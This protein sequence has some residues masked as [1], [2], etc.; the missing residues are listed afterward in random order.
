MIDSGAGASSALVYWLANPILNPAVLVFIGF[1]LGWQ[2]AALRLFVGVVLVFVLANLAARVLFLLTGIHP[3]LQSDL[4]TPTDRSFLPG[5]TAF[6]VL[7]SGWSHVPC[8]F[9]PSACSVRGS[10]RK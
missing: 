4:I 9:L 6:S 2:W 8:W 7:P 5:V 10:S 1:V 3:A